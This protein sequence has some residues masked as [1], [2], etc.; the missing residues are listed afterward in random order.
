M[1][2]SPYAGV[3]AATYVWSQVLGREG[4]ALKDHLDLAFKEIAAGGYDGVETFAS[5][6]QSPDDTAR[7]KNL[8]KKHGI[9]LTGLYRGG[10]FHIE[11]QAQKTVN[12]IKTLGEVAVGLGC[13]HLIVNPDPI[14]EREK[15]DDE[16]RCQAKF[17]NKAGALLRARDVSLDIH[18]HIPAMRNN[19]RELRWD[20][21]HT[22]PDFVH[23]CADVD[24]VYRGGVD[25][26]ELLEQYGSRIRGTHL[27][28]SVNKVWSQDL[29]EGDIDYTRIARLLR[30][31]GYPGW[32][33]VEL[34]YE[35]KTTET[36]SLAENMKR[37]R[38]FIR[39]VFGI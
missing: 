37:S 2:S 19:A 29:S 1:A 16:L 6:I 33:T 5:Y 31:A 23:L 38:S 25:P 32:L 4:K 28:N 24:W 9:K 14:H 36:R 35:E 39:R 22:D 7:V 11:E 30:A 12:E 26:Y 34:A 3:S 27:R 18:F 20:L 17:L 21:D 13:H 8:L 10:V 15:T